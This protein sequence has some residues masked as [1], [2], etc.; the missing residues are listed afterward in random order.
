MLDFQMVSDVE[1]TLDISIGFV[2]IY[3]REYQEDSLLFDSAINQS[4]LVIFHFEISDCQSF[5]LNYGMYILAGHFFR[6]T[7]SAAH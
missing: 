3:Q 2:F 4:D 7:C 6:Y 1:H 5:C